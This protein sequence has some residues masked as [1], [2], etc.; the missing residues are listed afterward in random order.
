MEEQEQEPTKISKSKRYACATCGE[1][2][3]DVESTTCPF[4]GTK[5]TPI[6]EE[7]APGALIGGRYLIVEAISGGGM[8]RVYKARHQLMKRTIAVKTLLPS[9][10]ASGAALKR[11]QQEA[12]ALSSL[13]HPNIL[14]VFDFFIAED[15]Q[16]YLVMDY[17][18]GTNLDQ[19][20]Q[21]EGP[22]SA[23]RAQRVFCQACSALAAA[24]AAG[25]I[26]RDLKPSN[27]MLVKHGV[28]ADNVK[29]IDFGIAKI[30]TAEDGSSEQLTATGE[31]FGSAQYMSPEQCRA[32]HPD[33]RSDI[34]SLGCVMYAS[35][36][37]KPPFIADDPIQCM[38]KQV[39]E[40]PAP[41][42]DSVICPTE[43]KNVVFKALKKNPAE[44]FQ[45][46]EEMNEAIYQAVPPPALPPPPPR[47]PEAQAKFRIA[48]AVLILIAAGCIVTTVV[49]VMHNQTLPTPRPTSAVPDVVPPAAVPAE[50]TNN[51]TVVPAEADP[52]AV[53]QTNIAEGE[54]Q[55]AAGHFES[56]K[57]SFN[58]AHKAA[59]QFGESDPRFLDSMEWQGK[60]AFQLGDYELSKQALKYVIYA[61]KARGE[62]HSSR[63]SEAE[64]TLKAIDAAIKRR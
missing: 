36:T 13:S 55:F 26:H 18:E 15:G 39:N 58:A 17:L 60:V 49:T 1:E 62:G 64:K 31:V 8:G 28:V 20:R 43:L 25:I 11:F 57:T 30:I 9:M 40:E 14:S 4:D 12:E 45:S 46:M 27:I 61:L 24:H 10:V 21:D 44:R 42:P 16:P 33:A 41:F 37:G 59:E 53:Y 22:M 56:A 32:Q 54:K 23:E 50:T 34:Y 29:V 47:T 52:K 2:Y 6:G 63:M 7:L 3:T 19:V 5:L 38:Y 51:T 35:L 48:N